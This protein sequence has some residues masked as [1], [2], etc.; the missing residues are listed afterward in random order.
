MM[1]IL[2]D[3]NDVTNTQ[4]FRNI[5][6]TGITSHH[7]DLWK[8]GND[9]GTYELTV[10]NAMFI[11]LLVAIDFYLFLEKT[12]MCYFFPSISVLCLGKAHHVIVMPSSTQR[13][14]ICV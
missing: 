1:L 2:R 8:V 10:I 4:L 12:I 14:D 13:L 7:A 6:K 3:F 5:A 9:Y 11:M